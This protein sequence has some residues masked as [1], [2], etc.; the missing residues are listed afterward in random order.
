LLAE[1]LPYILVGL[2]IGGVYAAF[3]HFGGW[4]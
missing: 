1:L 2:A 3:K 4:K